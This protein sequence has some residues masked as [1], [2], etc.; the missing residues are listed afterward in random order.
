[1]PVTRAY[2]SMPS[3]LNRLH[4]K[5]HTLTKSPTESVWCQS[6]SSLPLTKLE[7]ELLC[8]QA[9]LNSDVLKLEAETRDGD[10][11]DRRGKGGLWKRTEGRRWWRWKKKELGLERGVTHTLNTTGYLHGGPS[12][13][14][15][16]LISVGNL[17]DRH[18]KCWHTHTH[19]PPLTDTLTTPTQF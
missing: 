5:K 14:H 12:T 1:M 6:A 7:R 3:N 13:I 8:A 2:L 11:G 17:L 9:E 19:T 16:P 10:G 15:I 4:P 18:T